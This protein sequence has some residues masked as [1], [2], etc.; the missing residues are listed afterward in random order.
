MKLHLSFL[1]VIILLVFSCNQKPA[2]DKLDAETYNRYLETG[3]EVSVEAQSAL[4]SHVS[5]AMKEGGTLD[6]VEFCNLEASEIT[7][8]LDNIYN[9]TISRVSAKNRNPQNALSTE[10]EEQLWEYF[11]SVH[12]T[13]MIHDTVVMGGNQAVYYKPIITAMQACLQCHGPKEEIDPATYTK[14]L[15]LYPEDK[16]TGY[17]LNEL[18]GL[19]KIEFD[20]DEETVM[21]RKEK[22]GLL[23]GIYRNL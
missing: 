18:R 9:C 19:W 7:D 12:E 14:I 1:P 13:E 15:E 5:G 8:S 17:G 3:S 6:A 4:L 23:T 16:A 20:P 22:N 11:L 2:S 10:A 21:N